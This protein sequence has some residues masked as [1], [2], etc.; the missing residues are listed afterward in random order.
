[1]KEAL[2][3][4]RLQWMDRMFVYLAVIAVLNLTWCVLQQLV[5]EKSELINLVLAADTT[6]VIVVWGI[7]K[8]T[9]YRNLT[10]FIP[11]LFMTIHCID[12]NLVFGDKVP[13]KL[14]ISDK[15]LY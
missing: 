1:M 6:L 14:K 4:F 12:L 13:D 2:R 5:V 9:K 8:A 10:Q 15:T 3:Q 11:L 7:L